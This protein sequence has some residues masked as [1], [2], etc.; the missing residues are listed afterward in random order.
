MAS[1]VEVAVE[2]RMLGITFM[3]AVGEEHKGL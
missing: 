3:G 1:Y 2:V